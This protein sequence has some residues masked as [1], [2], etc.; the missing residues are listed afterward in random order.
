MNVSDKYKLLWFATPRSASRA[1]HAIFWDKLQFKNIYDLNCTT[2]T[3]EVVYDHNIYSD[4]K[5]IMCVRNPYSK[6]VSTWQWA[7]EGND[8]FEK[9]VLSDYNW[10]D[11]ENSTINIWDTYNR[12]VDFFIKYENIPYD[13]IANIK[14]DTLI[15][16]L[17]QIIEKYNLKYEQSF[18]NIKELV[19]NLYKS[20]K[21]YCE[22]S[23]IKNEC[24]YITLPSI[25]KV[26]KDM[27]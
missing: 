15:E 21:K 9:F 20:Y 26:F 19:F 1:L 4:Y 7:I 16:D 22:K 5:I 6:Y 13:T 10:M 27:I 24:I 25:T 12:S 8:T 17:E 14:S 3:H 18:V 2:C 11:V 23:A